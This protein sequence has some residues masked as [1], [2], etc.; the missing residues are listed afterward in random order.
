MFLVL[1]R[2]PASFTCLLAC[3]VSGPSTEFFTVLG[4]R[5]PLPSVLFLPQTPKA[6]ANHQ[7]E[8]QSHRK[9]TVRRTLSRNDDDDDEAN[10]DNHNNKNDRSILLQTSQSQH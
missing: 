5:S 7:D 2:F 3:F 8:T 9:C 10:D 6:D 1:G 4:H